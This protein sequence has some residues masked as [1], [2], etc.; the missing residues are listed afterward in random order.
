MEGGRRGKEG[1]PE[2]DLSRMLI[3]QQVP[4]TVQGVLSHAKGPVG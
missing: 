3:A 1:H 4:R 2:Q